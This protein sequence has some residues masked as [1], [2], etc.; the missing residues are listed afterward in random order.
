[1]LG[2]SLIG[3]PSSASYIIV[4]QPQS[5]STSLAYTLSRL[6]QGDA[7]NLRKPFPTLSTHE[8]KRLRGTW[9]TWDHNDAVDFP[10]GTLVKALRSKS[11][12]KNHVLPT[13]SNVRSLASASEG[14]QR[15]AFLLRNPANSTLG[16]CSRC[17][18]G[19]SM[20]KAEHC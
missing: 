7:F 12:Y 20:Q 3:G 17:V 9:S 6:L 18:Q 2:A 4:A 10:R 14:G 1:M 13:P 16:W 11:V 5:G 8:L 19:S 15:V